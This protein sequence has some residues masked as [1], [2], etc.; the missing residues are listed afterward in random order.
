[1]SFLVSLHQRRNRI[2]PES[3][4]DA[5]RESCWTT[6]CDGN[7]AWIYNWH[8]YLLR[9]AIRRVLDLRETEIKDIHQ[10]KG[11]RPMSI[12]QRETPVSNL[13]PLKQFRTLQ[14]IDVNEGQFSQHQLKQVADWTKTIVR[15]PKKR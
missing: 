5:R 6:T 9:K 10:L 8:C 4:V 2:R 13:A 1:M 7:F 11:L 15:D 14:Q 3:C 12:D